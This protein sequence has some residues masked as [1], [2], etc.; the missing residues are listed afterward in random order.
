MNNVVFLKKGTNSNKNLFLIHAGNGEIQ[1]YVLFCSSFS[2]EINCWGLRADRFNDFSPKNRSISSMARSYLKQIKK[3]QSCGPYLLAGWCFGG[4]RAFEIALQLESIGE[5]IDFL[6]IINSAPPIIDD[7]QMINMVNDYA[8]LEPNK[9]PNK[10]SR[11]D[12]GTEKILIH[13]WLS[14]I[15]S[16]NINN[17]L[18]YNK[19]HMWKIFVEMFGMSKYQSALMEVIKQDIPEDR[20]KAIPYFDNISFRDLI[21]YL[22]VMRTDANAQAFYMPARKVNADIHFFEANDSPVKR[23]YEWN[24]YSEHPI[25]IHPI[26]GD[27]FSIFNPGCVEKFSI[28]FNNLI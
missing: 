23:K 26:K 27:H 21:Y 11:F 20:A 12:L 9:N 6:S 4:V 14:Q 24:L 22:N 1:H 18:C 3:I 16:T 19:E 17:E 5:K 2:S 25:K 10:K 15:K 7:K 13:K 28:L 8:L